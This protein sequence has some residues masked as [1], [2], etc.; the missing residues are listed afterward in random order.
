MITDERDFMSAARLHSRVASLGILVV[1]TTLIW[2]L[3]QAQ[4]EARQFKL[5]D[6]DRGVKVDMRTSPKRVKAFKIVSRIHCIKRQS[7]GKQVT[8]GS[9]TWQAGK[10]FGVAGMKVP[11]R[12]DG[13]FVMKQHDDISRFVVK[14]K[15]AKRQIRGTLSFKTF[16]DEFDMEDCWSGKDR[17]DSWVRF[18]AP[19][20]R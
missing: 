4:A 6:K 18:V 3:V 10:A 8:Q 2:A 17:H 7:Q 19:L 5:V 20:R 15:V 12:S 14:G 11:I 9:L 16:A 13:R 1:A